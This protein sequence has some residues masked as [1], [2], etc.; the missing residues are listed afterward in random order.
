MRGRTHSCASAADL[1]SPRS[2]ALASVPCRFAT[3]ALR[4]RHVRLAVHGRDV[5]RGVLR[6]RRA[7]DVAAYLEAMMARR[8]PQVMSM[9]GP[10]APDE[11]PAPGPPPHDVAAG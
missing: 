8:F 2:F 1:G 9:Y 11:A 3:W 6:E 7:K 10:E 4:G 5:A